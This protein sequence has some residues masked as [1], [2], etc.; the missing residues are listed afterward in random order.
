MLPALA[1]CQ[2][3]LYIMLCQGNLDGAEMMALRLAWSF[4]AIYGRH[5]STAIAL[6]NLGI[7]KARQGRTQAAEALL[8]HALG[9]TLHWPDETTIAIL[10][11]LE[12]LL[13]YQGKMQEAWAIHAFVMQTP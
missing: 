10:A 12:L 11:N 4:L 7:I 6:N 8:R 5:P 1:V 9:A 2:G 3:F 13:C